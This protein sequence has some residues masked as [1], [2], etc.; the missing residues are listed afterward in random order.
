MASGSHLWPKG[1]S[2][3]FTQKPEFEMDQDNDE[4]EVPVK[5][6]GRP[7]KGVICGR[8]R[9]AKGAGP[10]YYQARGLRAP[11]TKAALQPATTMVTRSWVGLLDRKNY[12]LCRRWA[13]Y[14]GDGEDDDG[15]DDS[16]ELTPDIGRFFDDE[17]ILGA[18]CENG[19]RPEEE[20]AGQEQAGQ[21]H[22]RIR[23]HSL[24][25]SDH[26]TSRGRCAL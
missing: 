19:D 25:N 15:E 24:V 1:S 12:C 23:T 17:L 3:A 20:R 5:G 13:L 10:S 16:N 6:R 11:K 18:D 21:Y 9:P 8:G 14:R 2:R 26:T 4:R 7:R 22:E